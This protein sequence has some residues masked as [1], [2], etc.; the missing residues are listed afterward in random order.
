MSAVLALY[1]LIYSAAHNVVA[2]GKSEPQNE[3][4]CP[5]VSNQVGHK[6]G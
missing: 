2:N 1:E 4:I 5:W 6:L 3:K